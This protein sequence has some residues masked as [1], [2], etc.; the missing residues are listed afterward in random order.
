MQKCFIALFIIIL[1]LV[2]LVFWLAFLSPRPPLTADQATLDGDGSSI[3]YC[4][5]PL[6]NGS[7]KRAMDIPKGNTP[8]CSY[9]HFPLPILAHCTEALPAGAA[10]IRGLW[11]GVEGGHVG[12]VERAWRRLELAV[13][14]GRNHA[15]AEVRAAAAK[16]ARPN[17]VHEA[18]GPVR[19][20]DPQRTGAGSQVRPLRARAIE[21]A[22]GFADR[23]RDGPGL[24]PGRLRQN[25]AGVAV[26]NA[27]AH[28]EI[29]LK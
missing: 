13:G 4:K 7:G 12:H 16:A 2:L 14:A 17:L 5:M 26:V 18:R 6:L 22:G 11:R 8:G 27:E 1:V 23:V 25:H 28:L 3:N 15:F 10:D 19:L 21:G 24:Q 29:V 9:S 20:A